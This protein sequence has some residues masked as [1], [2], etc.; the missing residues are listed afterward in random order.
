MQQQIETIH[1][2]F[3]SQDEIMEA[4]KEAKV[5]IPADA[6]PDEMVFTFNDKV[7]K[8]GYIISWR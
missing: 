8:S 1:R 4:L 5:G 2:L 7:G 3:L 6:L